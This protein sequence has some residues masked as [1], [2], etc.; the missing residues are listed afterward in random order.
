V[1]SKSGFDSVDDNTG[2]VTE[3]TAHTYEGIED[4]PL[5]FGDM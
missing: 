3:A 1:Q 5:W 4:T 2:A